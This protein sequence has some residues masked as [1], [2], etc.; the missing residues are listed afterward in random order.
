[1]SKPLP[2]LSRLAN[3]DD[4]IRG[5]MKTIAIAALVI[6][7]FSASPAPPHITYTVTNNTALAWNVRV[8]WV[9]ASNVTSI[10]SQ[11]AGA[12]QNTTIYLPSATVAISA[13]RIMIPANA[14]VR[15]VA[16][17]DAKTIRQFEVNNC[18]CPGYQGHRFSVNFDHWDCSNCAVDGPPCPNQCGTGT[19]NYRGCTITQAN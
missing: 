4:A 15:A 16:G 14:T 12:N 10:T 1:M 8:S 6:P 9:N 2:F 5:A 17:C 18:L 19:C 11:V 13:V 7:L 3:V